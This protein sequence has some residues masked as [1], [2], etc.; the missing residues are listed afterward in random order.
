MLEELVTTEENYV[1]DLHSVLFGYRD[2]LEECEERIRQ[3]SEDIF[4]NLEEIYD[5]H[6]QVRLH[7]TVDCDVDE[8]I[9]QCLL[10]DLEHC[11]EDTRRLGKTFLEYSEGLRR[12][13]CRLVLSN[14]DVTSGF[15]F[16]G[17]NHSRV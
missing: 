12:I 4:G 11:G 7:C 6:S 5:F 1:E 16:Y 13:Y 9:F 14:S 2:R 17:F 8:E 15:W 10:P 3:K